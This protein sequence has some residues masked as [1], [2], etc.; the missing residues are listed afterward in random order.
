M[1]EDDLAIQI[2][3]RLKARRE[4][5]RL[6]QREVAER[7]AGPDADEKRLK[8]TL[9]AYQRWEVGRGSL[10]HLS[11]AAEALSTTPDALMGVSA[12]VAL[13]PEASLEERVAR[14]EA[15]L[16]DLLAVVE[17]LRRFLSS[18]ERVLQEANALLGEAEP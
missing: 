4:E 17:A 13:P 6:A 7:L 8:A 15:Q 5:L 1:T 10:R 16:G 9:R 18:P 12:P 2:G 14:L 3:R 11:E